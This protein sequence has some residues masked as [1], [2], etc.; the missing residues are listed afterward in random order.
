MYSTCVPVTSGRRRVD[1]LHGA[2]IYIAAAE[3]AGVMHGVPFRRALTPVYKG[4][5]TPPAIPVFS[6]LD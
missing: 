2:Y 1:W 4:E 5:I 3:A 6:E